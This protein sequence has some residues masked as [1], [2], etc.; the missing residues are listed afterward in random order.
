MQEDFDESMKVDVLAA[1]LRMEGKQSGDAMEN[2][3]KKLELCLPEH[4]TISRDGWFLSKTKPVKDLL[5]QFD[6]FHY[7]LTREKSGSITARQMKIV[8]G[9][10]LKTTEISLDQWIDGLAGEMAELAKKNS[11]TREALSRLI[12]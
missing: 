10:A 5:V 1:S 12:S 2:L 6:N 7:Q 11:Q 3:A 8:R 9:V 4:V